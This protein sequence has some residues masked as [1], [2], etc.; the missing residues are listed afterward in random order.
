VLP[1]LATTPKPPSATP[2][3]TFAQPM[4]D[5][6]APFLAGFDSVGSRLLI[7]LGGVLITSILAILLYLLIRQRKREESLMEAAAQENQ[8]LSLS[9]QPP[10]GDETEISLQKS[11][12]GVSIDPE[13]TLVA[14]TD[15]LPTLPQTKRNRE[16]DDDWFS[17]TPAQ[18]ALLD[19]E[20]VTGQ[21]M[22]SLEG[23]SVI[24][25]RY[26]SDSDIQHLVL[27][28]PTISRQHSMIEYKENAYWLRDLKSTN[29]TFVNG[30]RLT[31]TERIKLAHG[32]QL[33]FHRFDFEFLLKDEVTE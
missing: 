28:Q 12:V 29:G 32:D 22:V 23:R 6:I 3:E 2:S 16:E 13:G 14:T 7:S 15:A 19:L 1:S 20:A 17:S 21:D 27:N 11:D 30:R 18:A 5:Q 25:S 10:L 33:R 31:V 9:D 8:Q 24:I 26:P 4:R